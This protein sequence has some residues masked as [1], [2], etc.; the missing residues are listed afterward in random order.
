MAVIILS[1]VVANEDMARLLGMVTSLTVAVTN[2]TSDMTDMKKDMSDMKKDMTD[3]KKNVTDMN[4]KIDRIGSAVEHV[5]S[6]A[7]VRREALEP[8]T[9]SYTIPLSHDSS[10]TARFTMFA[11]YHQ[12]ATVLAMPA[13]AFNF[14]HPGIKQFYQKYLQHTSVRC[15]GTDM[16]IASCDGFFASDGRPHIVR[17]TDARPRSVALPSAALNITNA[18]SLKAGQPTVA[19]GYTC[20][21]NPRLWYAT[22]AG[23]YDGAITAAALGSGNASVVGDEYLYD[24]TQLDCASGSPALNSKSVAGMVLAY[25]SLHGYPRETSQA[26]VSPASHLRDCIG[27]HAHRFQRSCPDIITVVN[28]PIYDDHSQDHQKKNTHDSKLSDTGANETVLTTEGSTRHTLTCRDGDER[29]KTETCH[30]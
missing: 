23:M 6:F 30:R 13:H 19:Y 17:S 26:F 9:A 5:H 22:V 10:N 2:L 18:L 4:V 3:L 27:R 28:P 24:A 21:G 14:T 25:Q 15:E 8:T 20:S 11:A 12:G 1:S 7:T 16:V 29:R